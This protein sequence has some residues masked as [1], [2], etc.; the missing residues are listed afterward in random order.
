M[1]EIYS[2]PASVA[3]NA[4]VKSMDAYRNMYQRSIDDPE[5][6]WAEQAEQFTWF[7]KWREVR[8]FNYNVKN[9]PVDIQWFIGG[10]TNI[11]VNCIDRHLAGRADRTAIL[12]EGN[13]PGETRALTYRELH[14]SVSRFA[15]VLKKYGIGKG[16]RV[17][18]YM[19]M[20][21]ELA[22]AMLAVARIG[23]VHSIVFGGFSAQSLAERIHDSASRLIVTTDGAF[24][25]Q[26]PVP[27]KASVDDAIARAAKEGVNV[28]TCIVVERVGGKLAV[29][30]QPGRD[31]WWHDEMAQA[32]PECEAESMDA[33]DP[34]FI[35]YTSGSTGKPKGVQ[36]NVGGYMVYAAMTH[37][38]IF[39]YHDGDIWWCTADIGWVTGH[40]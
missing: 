23:A 37:K 7:E 17:T 38:Y 13:E 27:L 36:H 32:S 29:E 20:V 24:R 9:G 14:E 4:W 21:P 35:L 31:H 5:G 15:N 30:M 18:L 2:P 11:T 16:D 25:G 6:F 10:R 8:R 40:S 33:E 22:V 28:T 39:D 26:K 3:E 34:L 1:E 19:P 12:W